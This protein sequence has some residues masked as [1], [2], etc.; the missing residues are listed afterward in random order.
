MEKAPNKR[1]APAT[2]KENEGTAS[3]LMLKCLHFTSKCIPNRKLS[4]ILNEE[5]LARQQGMNSVT[6]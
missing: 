5:I 1:T 6:L 3:S 2:L 4:A